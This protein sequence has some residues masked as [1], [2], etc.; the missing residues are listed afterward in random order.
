MIKRLAIKFSAIKF[1]AFKFP[2]LG[3]KNNEGPPDL[4]QVMRDI[5]QKINNLFGKGTSGGNTNRPVDGK[6]FSVPIAPILAIVA[7]IL[8]IKARSV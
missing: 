3:Q 2:G 4:D 1:S 5:T 6:D 8:S 7:A